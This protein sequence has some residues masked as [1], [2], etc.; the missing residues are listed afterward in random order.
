MARVLTEEEMKNLMAVLKQDAKL[1]Y[2]DTVMVAIQINT[3]EK[4]EAPEDQLVTEL[5]GRYFRLTANELLNK[6]AKI[7][8]MYGRD[9]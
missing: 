7:D 2:E 9:F 4:P 1:S 8:K 6:T 3:T 5:E